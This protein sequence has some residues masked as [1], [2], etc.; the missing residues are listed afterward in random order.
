[1]C[2]DAQGLVRGEVLETRALQLLAGTADLEALAVS[3]RPAPRPAQGAPTKTKPAA[4]LAVYSLQ[5]FCALR[6]AE[7]FF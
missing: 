3:G 2:A 7:V 5:V 4:V 1:M 6:W